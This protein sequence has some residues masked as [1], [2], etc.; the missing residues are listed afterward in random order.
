MALSAKNKLRFIDGTIT[1]PAN[2]SKD[3]PQWSR[4]N[5]MVRSWLLNS[6]STDIFT[7]VIYCNFARDIWLDLKER[8]SQVNGPRMFQL[9]QDVS[10][11]IQGTMPIAT[12]FT[13]LKG[14]WDELSALQPIPSCTCGALKEGLKLQQCQRTI[15]FLMGLNESYATVR[16]QLLLMEPLPLVNSA[17]ALVLQKECQCSITTPPTIEGIALAAKGNLPPW[18]DN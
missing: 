11:L 7:T 2:S 5:N 9:K 1:P 10:T 14:L 4:C 8:F 15:K 13:K 17:Y 6:I 16:G 3:F 12:C 18:K